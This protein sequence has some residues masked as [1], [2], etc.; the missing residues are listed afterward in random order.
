MSGVI[1]VLLWVLVGIFIAVFAVI[2]YNYVPLDKNT[3]NDFE[4]I[5]FVPGIKTDPIFLAMW[6]QYL[7]YHFPDTEVQFI[8]GNYH[9]NDIKTVV[10]IQERLKVVLK[11]TKKTAVIVHSYGGIQII[12]ALQSGEI[13]TSSIHAIVA[14]APAFDESFE[15]L[16]ESREAIGYSNSKIDVP[17]KT[18]CGFFDSTVPCISTVFSGQEKSERLIVDHSLFLVP[19]IFHG[20]R[21]IKEL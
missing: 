3:E 12:S 1:S 16:K 7:G 10:D 6:K 14:L 17:I 9:Y 2:G 19:Q 18:F 21:I 8:E 15:D 11:D 13:D 20:K 5:V 4:R